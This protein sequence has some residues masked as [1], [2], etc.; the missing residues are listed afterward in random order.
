MSGDQPM[1]TRLLRGILAL[2]V[3]WFAGLPVLFVFIGSVSSA[4]GVWDFTGRY[5]NEVFVSG[6]YLTPLLNTAELAVYTGIISTL[7]GGCLAWSLARVNLPRPDLLEL[8]IMTPVFMSPFIGAMGWITLAQPRAGLLNALTRYLGWPELDVFTYWGT[9][10]V[11]STCFAPYAY[12]MLRHSIERLNPEMEEAAAIFGANPLRTGLGVILPMLWPSLLSALIFTAILAAEMFSIPGILIV[13]EGFKLLSYTIFVRTTRWPLNL[14]EA[15]AAGVLLLLVTLLG[16]LL[17]SWVIRVQERFISVGPKSA[18]QGSHIGSRTARIVAL[19]L[20]IGFIT[21]G[22][23]LPVV[24]IGIRSMLPFFSGQFLLSDLSLN[25]IRAALA[26]AQ[27][28]RAL[29]NSVFVTV[30][31]VCLLTSI[32]F[33]IALEKIRRP[34]AISHATSVIANIPIAV[35]GVLFG[36]GL[37]WL[38]IR[39]PVYA[40]IWILVLVMLARFLP[41]LVRMFETAL[42]QLGKELDEAAAVSGASESTITLRIRLPLLAGTFRSVFVVGGTQVFNELTAS[43][44]LYTSSSALL[45]VI[46]FNYMF[47]GDYSRAAAVAMIQIGLLAIGFSAISIAMRRTYRRQR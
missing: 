16:I 26:D 5:L 35:P 10:L 14:S 7:L 31:S 19:S 4:P 17:Y 9:V 32:A 24:A 41:I 46:V 34:N 28:Q 6:K 44:L 3:F 38:Y 43:A 22:V 33:F 39:T 21:C 23:V 30:L 25:N 20:V 11:M 13:P 2:S 29:I 37:L 42:M 1:G 40:T 45:P 12:S 8:G 47:D 15:A 18:R 27:V 36:V